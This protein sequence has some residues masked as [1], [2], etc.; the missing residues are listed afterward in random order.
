ME[1]LV[2]HFQMSLSAEKVHTRPKSL[3]EV[4]R[5]WE[6]AVQ[7]RIVHGF[8]SCLLQDA[9][10]ELDALLLSLTENLMDHTVTPQVNMPQNSKVD[11]F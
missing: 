10:D 11:L 2:A 7:C 9:T 3:L 4:Q 6:S 1:S 8:L 5:L